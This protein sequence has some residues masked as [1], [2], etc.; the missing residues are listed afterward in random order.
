MRIDLLPKSIRKRVLSAIYL[1]VKMGLEDLDYDIGGFSEENW[2]KLSKS[3]RRDYSALTVVF[4][5]CKLLQRE[6]DGESKESIEKDYEK[7]NELIKCIE[8]EYF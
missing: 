8:E 6:L 2:D 5:E 4:N 3:Q 7:V 1:T